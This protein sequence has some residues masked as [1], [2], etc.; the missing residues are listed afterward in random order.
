MTQIT[1]DP[2]FAAPKP[3]AGGDA[4]SP[5]P[6]GADFAAILAAL[7]G[8][9][10]GRPEPSAEVN[11]MLAL[12]HAL[13][14][15]VAAAPSGPSAPGERGFLGGNE[16]EPAAT[17]EAP[18]SLAAI[19]NEFG[20]FGQALPGSA[21]PVDAPPAAAPAPPRA[22]PAAPALA[23]QAGQQSMHAKSPSAIVPGHV[24]PV[25]PLPTHPSPSD[26]VPRD[27]AGRIDTHTASRAPAAA[28]DLPS[29]VGRAAD[30]GAITPP[31]ATVP[32]PPQAG[33]ADAALGPGSDLARGASPVAPTAASRGPREAPP[34]PRFEAS[35]PTQPT[36]TARDEAHPA[37][38]ASRLRQQPRLSS[39]A[40]LMPRVSLAL[41]EQGA[42]LVARLEGISREERLRLRAE[43]EQL[44]AAYG[45]TPGEIRINGAVDGRRV[46]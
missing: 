3:L 27:H 16:A 26:A 1:L 43:A 13:A 14:A 23:D 35:P 8:Q 31:V 6:A 42:N 20:L 18:R 44:L 2:R 24:D 39:G 36:K 9:G 5:A 28:V 34:A 32:M 15:G 10:R 29:R 30:K 11:D 12:L 25:R 19:F 21:E 4:A 46:S 41:A 33:G 37:D 7:A 45:L 22:K 17:A 40:N 38:A